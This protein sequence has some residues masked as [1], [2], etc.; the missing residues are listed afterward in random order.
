MNTDVLILAEHFKGQLNEV[1]FELLGKGRALASALGGKLNVLVLGHEVRGFVAELGVADRVCLVDSPEF[2][3]F[4]PEAYGAAL[5]VVMKD[6]QPR[7][8]L[9]GSTS[10]GMDLLSLVS[11]KG[12]SPCLDNCTSLEVCE[13]RV[14]ATC[15]I[16][17]GKVYADVPIPNTTTVIA[18]VPGTFPAE[19]GRV[20]GKPEVQALDLPASLLR[21]RT[22]FRK[23]IEPPPGD[24]D[25][26]QARVLVAVG[27]GIQ[28]AENLPLAEELAGALGGA[29]CA[30]RPVVD[31]G[32]LPLTRQVGK[33]GMTVKPKLY[34][35]FG[36]SGAPEHVEG[37]KQ[38]EMIIA[39]NTDPKA[40]IFGVAHYGVVADALDLMPLLAEEVR[41]RELKKA[42]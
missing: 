22:S 23:M 10:V 3:N 7:L 5:E 42:S 18:V 25:I 32:W 35:A 2:R 38:A 24:V 27:R 39:V 30:S 28:N 31:Q 12:D 4:I 16:Y 8:L 21:V 6:L 20:T 9:L 29:V 15:Q 14:T 34:L 1:T 33:S 36:I 13:G 17:G 41:R 40:P 26:T 37:M 19:T 11:A